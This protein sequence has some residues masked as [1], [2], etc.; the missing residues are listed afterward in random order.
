[1]PWIT[2]RIWKASFVKRRIWHTALVT[3]FQARTTRTNAHCQ[4]TARREWATLCYTFLP[5]SSFFIISSSTRLHPI[6]VMEKLRETNKG[7]KRRAFR[8][9]EQ[10]YNAK[11]Q[12][13]QSSAFHA[14]EMFDASLFNALTAKS[15]W[16]SAC[17]SN[18]FTTIPLLI[19]LHSKAFQWN[20]ICS[21]KMILKMIRKIASSEYR[22]R[23]SCSV[24]WG[25]RKNVNMVWCINIQRSS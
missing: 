9:R 18:Y 24:K 5:S 2:K 21:I 16:K 4:C 23:G 25:H 17:S 19:F 6:T 20:L 10:G 14:N 13:E 1:M 8:P 11:F 22:R 3:Q 15:A 12:I 7:E